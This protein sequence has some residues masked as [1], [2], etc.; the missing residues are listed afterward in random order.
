MG[1]YENYRKKEQRKEQETFLPLQLEL[2]YLTPH[3]SSSTSHF[4]TSYYGCPR[5]EAIH[6]HFAVLSSHTVQKRD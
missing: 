5:Q 1:I 2:A 3:Q 4:S 6:L